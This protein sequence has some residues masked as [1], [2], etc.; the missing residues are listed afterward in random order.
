MVCTEITNAQSK[1]WYIYCPYLYT[2]VEWGLRVKRGVMGKPGPQ[3]LKFIF[4]NFSYFYFSGRY[5]M[6]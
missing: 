6:F 2:M 5:D 1:N 4:F 3:K